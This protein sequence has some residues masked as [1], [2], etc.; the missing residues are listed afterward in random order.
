MSTQK[1]KVIL[2]HLKYTNQFFCFLSYNRFISAEELLSIVEGRKV[3]FQETI[4]FLTDK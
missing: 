2:E 4:E 1:A 3:T